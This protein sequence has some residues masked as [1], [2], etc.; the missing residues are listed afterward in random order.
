MRSVLPLSLACVTPTK[1]DLYPQRI[2]IVTAPTV[3]AAALI[4][5]YCPLAALDGLEWASIGV[6]DGIRS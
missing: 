2:V 5:R 1:V 4:A 3:L 6:A